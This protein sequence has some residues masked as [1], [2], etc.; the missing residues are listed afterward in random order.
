MVMTGVTELVVFVASPSD[1]QDER[2]AVRT[3]AERLEN[4]IGLSL[5]LRIRVAGWEQV[6][7][8][9][10]R[11]QG[12]I[13]QLVDSCDIFIGILNTR[14]GTE[15]GT[16]SS[17]F[18]EEF[19]RAVARFG[20]SGSP[21][22]G[23]F[24]K[25][26]PQ[27]QRDDAGPQLKKVLNFQQRILSDHLLLYKSFN[28]T[29]DFER[30]LTDLLLTH[31]AKAIL[32]SVAG[33]DSPSGAPPV[34]ALNIGAVASSD[35][36]MAANAS[37]SLD[38]AQSQVA[39]MLEVYSALIRG[40]PNDS[41]LDNDRLL[42][43][44]LT[45]SRGILLPTHEANRLYNRRSELKLLVGEQ[46]QWLRSMA[47]DCSHDREFRVI[48]GWSVVGKEAVALSAS[49]L[50][51]DSELSVVAG[52]LKLLSSIEYRSRH[53]LPDLFTDLESGDQNK[54]LER[55]N[56]LFASPVT[57]MAAT[58]Y[59]S[60][61]ATSGDYPLLNALT[62]EIP[63]ENGRNNIRVLIQAISRDFSGLVASI[64]ASSYPPQWQVDK[65]MMAVQSLSK[66]DLLRLITADA[67]A[68]ID[69]LRSA[70]VAQLIENEQIDAEV[71]TAVLTGKDEETASV[72]VDAA[73]QRDDASSIFLAALESLP[74]GE[75][76]GRWRRTWS[77]VAPR[78]LAATRSP[79]ELEGMSQWNAIAWEARLY[80]DHG[81]AEVAVRAM[82][83]S[84]QDSWEASLPD[85]VREAMSEN[86]L[87]SF[88]YAN[89][90]EAALRYLSRLPEVSD[91]DLDLIRSRLTSAQW[92]IPSEAAQ[93]L[94]QFKISGDA[95]LIFDATVTANALNRER[96]LA[97][98]LA[99]GNIE[100]IEAA[101]KN[102]ED[103]T[104]ASVIPFLSRLDD[105]GLTSLLTHSAGQIRIAASDELTRRLSSD[106][107]ESLLDEY[108]AREHHYYNVVVVLDKFLY[109][110]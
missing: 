40:I 2:A 19:D 99:M 1:V 94:S 25:V 77:S 66:Q 67:A 72:I 22:I 11:P 51:G 8:G 10:G 52:S 21:E 5:G 59:L 90:I 31:A 92:S 28:D 69:R 27:S 42:L 29:F 82:L 41:P 38:D 110:P 7:P 88:I 97:A 62:E 98:A 48:P 73:F 4:S 84:D 23:M 86:D 47:A 57:N 14:W 85:A 103:S 32:S 107:I 101:I 13:N 104:A 56:R 87:I 79:E 109:G 44:A 35:S 95:Q 24:F 76:E 83:E 96:M 106:Q 91:G 6:P 100:V 74:D 30:Q 64:A 63:D 108:T 81:K 26:V 3:V 53:L 58:A 20:T 70:A 93:S 46:R 89:N 12:Q 105:A 54:V 61:V 45:V 49:G 78:I 43:F 60:T 65:L 80:Q 71:I 37:T 68:N 75:R 33:P 50:L 9:Y 15:S 18:S 34:E 16:H 102:A 39:E 36:N 55:W 17:G